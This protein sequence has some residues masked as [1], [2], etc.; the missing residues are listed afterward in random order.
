ML[1]LKS[2]SRATTCSLSHGITKTRCTIINL[3]LQLPTHLNVPPRTTENLESST[4]TRVSRIRGITTSKHTWN[5]DCQSITMTPVMIMNPTRE[6]KTSTQ[7]KK[8]LLMKQ[9]ATTEWTQT[10]ITRPSL[11][12]AIQAVKWSLAILHIRR[13]SSNSNTIKK[14]YRLH[15]DRSIPIYL[16]KLSCFHSNNQLFLNNQWSTS[17]ECAVKQPAR[18]TWT[19]KYSRRPEIAVGS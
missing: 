7:Q 8:Q 9:E 2:L 5:L 3:T 13:K 6:A 18:T 19:R 10:Q 14:I 16:R 1:N 12:Q 17:Q 4:Y 15:K 11:K